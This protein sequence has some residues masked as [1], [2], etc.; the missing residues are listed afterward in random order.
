MQT[1]KELSI[2]EKARLMHN[3]YNR[4]WYRKNK[5]KVKRSRIESLAR[6]YDAAIERGED[7][8]QD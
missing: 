2:E 7:I 5:Q 8:E 3:Q 1:E 6:A 4:E